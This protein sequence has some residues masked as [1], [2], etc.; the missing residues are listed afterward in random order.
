LNKYFR[1]ISYNYVFLAISTLAFLILTPIAIRVMGEEM[2]G[3]WSML[4]AILLFSGIGVLGMGTVVNKFASEGGNNALPIN[5][6]LSA[7]F[8]IL[9]PMS[10]LV[11]LILFLGRGWIASQFGLGAGYQEQFSVAMIFTALSIIPQFLGRVPQGY[12]LSQLRNK[13]ART[14]EL[15]VNISMLAGAVFIAYLTQSLIWMALWAFIVQTIGMTILFAIVL[16][17]VFFRWQVE[18]PALRRLLSFS[19]FSFLE[20]LAISLFQQFDRILVGFLLGPAA[21]G[22]YSVG[23][24]IALRLPIIAGQATEVMLPY[25]S[26]TN[27]YN[28]HSVLLDIFRVLSK[29]IGI[30]I[31]AIAAILILWMDI[32]LSLWISPE[33]A[34]KYSGVF[35]ILVIAYFILSSTR[36][37]HQT[38]TGMGKVKYTSLVYLATTIFMLFTVYIFSNRYGLLGAAIANLSMLG[39]VLMNFNA[40]KLLTRAPLVKS[41]LLDYCTGIIFL[42]IALL[43]TV[44]DLPL[45]A[46]IVSSLLIIFL[47]GYKIMHDKKIIIYLKKILPVFQQLKIIDD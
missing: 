9:L 23:T 21:A 7:A 19:G 40:Y 4:N 5:S 47:M 10:G 39:L 26:K 32:I 17:E 25:A 29:I 8:L 24:S 20:S 30:L 27:S 41:I 15:G 37:A 46:K 34:E 36:T 12:L 18:V 13:L 35:R 28:D 22:V 3:L 42:L 16:P 43:I 38:L 2:Y 45:S 31:G 6:I 1:A 33:Y 14:I 44:L 11:A